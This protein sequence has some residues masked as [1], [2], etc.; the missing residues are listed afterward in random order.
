MVSACVPCGVNCSRSF[1]IGVAIVA[2]VAIVG[3]IV[4]AIFAIVAFD[5][6]VGTVTTLLSEVNGSVVGIVVNGSVV[7][8]VAIVAIGAIV[9]AC[10]TTVDFTPFFHVCGSVVFTRVSVRAIA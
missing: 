4:G 1:L 3:A 10:V 6:I 9:G 5:A 2:I 8:I 7:A